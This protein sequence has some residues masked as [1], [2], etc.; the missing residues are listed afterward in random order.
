MLQIGLVQQTVQ[1]VASHNL[2]LLV[3]HRNMHPL[4]G[5]REAAVQWLKSRGLHAALRDWSFGESVIVAAGRQI[6]LQ[7]DGKPL[8]NEETGEEVVVYSHMLCIYPEQH[9]WSVALLSGGKQETQGYHSLGEATLEAANL[10]VQ[11]TV[12][13]RKNSDA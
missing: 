5:T 8:R 7:E 4:L 13:Q 2:T 11:T 10:L 6:L 1:I 9:G 3:S 12:S